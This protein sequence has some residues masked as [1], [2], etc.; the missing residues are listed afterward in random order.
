M[1]EW[2]GGVA[3]RLH[4]YAIISLETRK[5]LGNGFYEDLINYSEE[6]KEFWKKRILYS[7]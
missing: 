5:K 4:N 3:N 1:E 7:I 2:G 6:F